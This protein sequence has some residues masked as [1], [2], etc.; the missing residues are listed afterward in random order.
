MHLDARP[1]RFIDISA[2]DRGAVRMCTT[3]TTMTTTG[4]GT[5][6][7]GQVFVRD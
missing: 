3:T 5:T 1:H 6:G 4:T 7:P 2:S